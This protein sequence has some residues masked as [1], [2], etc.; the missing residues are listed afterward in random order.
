[1]RIKEWRNGL[2]V[3]VPDKLDFALAALPALA[4]LKKI[5]P[6]NCGLFVVTGR[7]NI[8]LYQALEFVDDIIVLDISRRF[9]SKDECRRVKQL[10]A[11]A[12]LLLDYRF[13]D[14]FGLKLAGV[15][16]LYGG[17]NSWYSLFFAGRFSAG[18]SEIHGL[19]HYYNS[20]AKAFGGEVFE[21][22]FPDFDIPLAADEL[23]GKIPYLFHHPLLLSIMPVKGGFDYAKVALWWIRHGG[24]VAL[25][26]N[27]R[28]REIC[29]NIAQKLPGKKCFD[30][31]GRADLF[32]MMYVFGFSSF[33]I[34]DDPGY[35]CL[36]AVLE[37]PGLT[38]CDNE[39]TLP[40]GIVSNK[41]ITFRR[42]KGQQI[43]PASIIRIVHKEA[44]TLNLPLQKSRKRK[45]GR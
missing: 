24:I 14:V 39:N 8:Q 21:N 10:H 13:K 19:L 36:G 38:V 26:G 37:A 22:S 35:A 11:G 7:E 30:F 25:F 45:K 3:R 43:T 2:L 44:K 1:M 16:V 31:C 6:E 4:A 15:P 9:W 34:V 32:A 17:N 33:S 12:A 41:W 42:E 23:T 20:I 18:K 27:S 28:N 40:T 29:K 5:V